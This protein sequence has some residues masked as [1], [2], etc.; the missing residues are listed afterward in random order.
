MQHGIIDCS[1][2]FINNGPGMGPGYIMADQGYDVWFGNTRGNFYSKEHV[3]Y[4]PDKDKEYWDFSF[5]EMGRFD[6]PA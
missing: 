2:T 4:N 3:K 1:D 6:I 5:E